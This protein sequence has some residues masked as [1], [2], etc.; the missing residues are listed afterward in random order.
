MKAWTRND[1]EDVLWT[2]HKDERTAEARI[3]IA[4]VGGGQ[5]EL[6]LYT[7][8]ERRDKFVMLY[9]QVMKDLRTAR[10]LAQ[11]KQ[12]EFEAQG[13]KERDMSQDQKFWERAHANGAFAKVSWRRDVNEY[14]ASAGR[15]ADGGVF[16]TPLDM[17]LSNEH[18][19]RAIADRMAHPECD[20]SCPPWMEHG[21]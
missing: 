10:S 11:E 9:R 15:E 6:R 18:E 16:A 14:T 12:A 17:G 4:P 13:W 2:L 7:N 5:P 20:G 8:R 3:G 19:A 21:A 1:D